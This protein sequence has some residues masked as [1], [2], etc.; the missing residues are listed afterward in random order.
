[1]IVD[2]ILYFSA[3]ERAIILLGDIDL[4]VF[5]LPDLT[6]RLSQE[7]A[8]GAVNKVRSS[9]LKFLQSKSPEAIPFKGFRG[10]RSGICLFAIIETMILA[11][12]VSVVT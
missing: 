3:V 7:G 5:R 12:L 9:M 2:K 11:M 10:S 8:S 1:M 6:Y 4:D